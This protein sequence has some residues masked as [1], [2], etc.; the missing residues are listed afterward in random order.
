[1]GAFGGPHIVTD[2][3]ELALDGLNTKSYP[4]SGT[5]WY[6]L[7]GNDNDGTLSGAAM[8]DNGTTAR[9]IGFDGTNDKVTI[10]ADASLRPAS[11]FSVEAWVYIGSYPASWYSLIQ[12]PQSN[13]SH[14]NPYFDWAIYIRND[15]GLH[16]R[17]DGTDS[18]STG[19]TTKVPTGQ[20]SHIVITWTGGLVS[21]YL[22]GNLIQT[23]S[24][25]VTSITYDNNTDVLIGVNASSTE[26][27][28]GNVGYAKFYSIRLTAAQVAQNFNA[29]KQRFGL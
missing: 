19:T 9:N 1:M 6:D 2:G 14:T 20:W 23:H 26:D 29:N 5:T 24:I 13:A 21:Y 17:V 15:G 22:Q 8:Q 16:T 3:L 18:L 25:G 11:A 28:N 27:F 12:A 7:S 10:P 4:G